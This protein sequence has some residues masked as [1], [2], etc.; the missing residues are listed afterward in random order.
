M[1]EIASQGTLLPKSWLLPDAFRRRMGEDAGRQRLMQEEG[2]FLAILHHIPKAE[3]KG[4]R[5]GAFFWIDGEG[6]WKSAPASGGRSALRAHVE[7]YAARARALDD[8]LE[9]T[10]RAEEVHEVIDQAAP[11]QRAARNMLEVLQDLRTALPD[12]GKVLA[13]RDLAVGVERTMDLLVQDAKSS[14]DFLIAKSAGEQAVAAA[15]ATEEARK[16]NR[17]AAFFF[18]LLTLAAIFGISRPSEVLTYDWFFV[19][20]AVGLG[21]GAV[22]WS[23]VKR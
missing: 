15:S 11:L 1:D 12:D 18:P 21:I 5:E 8:F 13:I 17:L 2:Q 3:D 19:L 10:T 9:K 23:L 14:L 4:R 22:V 16:L 20:C 6:N 7:A